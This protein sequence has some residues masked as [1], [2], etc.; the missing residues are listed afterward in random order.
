MITAE[1][2]RRNYRTAFDIIMDELHW[3]IS[4]VSK[5]ENFYTYIVPLY[6]V[7]DSTTI[8]NVISSLESNGFEVSYRYNDQ[9][10]RHVLIIK[11]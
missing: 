10:N 2:A 9:M 3:K 6:L 5:R 11:W 7:K 4:G 1:D 8:P